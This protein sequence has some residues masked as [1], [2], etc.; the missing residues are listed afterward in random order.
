MGS[1]IGLIIKHGLIYG[2]AAT[3]YLFLLILTLS[4]RVW[5]YADYPQAVKDKVPPQTKREKLTALI[6]GIPWFLFVFVYPVA[7][8][9]MI[10]SALGGEIS[11]PTAILCPVACFT[12][13]TFGD[14]VLVDW[15]YISKLTP[16]RVMIRGTVAEDYKDF[17]EHYRGHAKSVVIMALISVGIGLVAHLT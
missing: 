4:P 6:V 11:L 2:G 15:L 3:G 1:A 12:L 14:L 9:S 8:T 10:K 16:K 5:G 13:F 17:S 7:S